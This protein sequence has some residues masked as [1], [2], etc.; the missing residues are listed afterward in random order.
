MCLI[1]HLYVYLSEIILNFSN[2]YENTEFGP[3]IPNG[4]NGNGM[5]SRGTKYSPLPI[6]RLE[7]EYNKRR[8]DD[9]KLF[10][11]EFHVCIIYNSVTFQDILKCHFSRFKKAL[12]RRKQVEKLIIKIK[13][14]TQTFCLVSLL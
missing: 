1:L 5:H 4:T 7:L 11:E 14:A 6:D 10:R 9:D 3:L 13:I 12:D 2:R 8:G